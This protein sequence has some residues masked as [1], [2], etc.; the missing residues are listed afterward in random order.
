MPRVLSFPDA[1]H[2]QFSNA[3]L[4]LMLGQV[5]FPTILK[6]ASP[7]GLAGLQ[8]ELRHEYSEYSEEQQLGLLV[9]SEGMQTASEAKNYR[10]ATADGAWSVIVN[11]TSM[12]LEAST[13]TKYS[14][15]DEFESRYGGLWAAALSH[16]GPSRLVQQGLRY[17][18][19]FDWADVEFPDWGKYIAPPLLGA[20][21]VPELAGHV[22]HSIT[23]ARFRLE[24][25]GT[26]ALKYGVSRGGPQNVMGFLLD[27]DVFTQ[28]PD[29]DVSVEAVMRRF[30]AFHEEIHA[31]FSWAT[32]TEA[33][34][35]F[36][37]DAG[38]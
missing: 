9:G 17:I 7:G 26:M 32:T 25:L 23:D 8:E 31:F 3:P 24:P 11:P 14:T 37:H 28:T 1:D 4:K 27:T 36:S 35:R 2:V 13:A 10:F 15:Y 18:D 12:T 34:E 22:E 38:T 16:L 19:F 6:I 21:G 5:R 30:K 29:E 33:R 20:T